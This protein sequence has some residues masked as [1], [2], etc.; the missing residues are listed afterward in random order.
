MSTRKPARRA[1]F[2]DKDGTLVDNVPYNVDP[3]LVAFTPNALPGL[4]LLGQ[5]GYRLVVVS[6]Q[7]GVALGYFDESALAGLR[8]AVMVRLA[9][10]G[11]RLSGFYCCVHAPGAGCPCRKPLPGL[12]LRAS[13]VLNI[14]LANSW[15]VGDILDDV[16]AGHRAGCRSVLLDVGNETEWLASP[17]RHPDI[18]ARDLLEAARAI[19]AADELAARSAERNAPSFRVLA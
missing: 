3:G 12:L 5:L 17:L 9:A 18:T 15:M 1:V 10:Q 6:N 11:V 19:V 8:S 13:Q 7:P 2:I 16:E 4:R 14:D